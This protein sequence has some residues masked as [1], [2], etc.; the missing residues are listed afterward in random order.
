MSNNNLMKASARYILGEST[1][2]KIKGSSKKIK[3]FQE[4]LSASKNLYDALC[5]ERS[6]DEVVVLAETKKLAASNF[7]KITGI[8]WRL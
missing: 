2:V 6:L 1:G 7:R 4:V 5:E 3:T 8:T